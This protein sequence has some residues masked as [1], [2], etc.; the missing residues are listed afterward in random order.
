MQNAQS[1]ESMNMQEPVTHT[2]EPALVEVMHGVILSAVLITF[3]YL[4]GVTLWAWNL[5]I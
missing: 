4:W 2:E 5:Q 3:S 1:Q